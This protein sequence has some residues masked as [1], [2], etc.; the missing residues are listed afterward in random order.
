M[1]RHSSRVHGSRGRNRLYGYVCALSLVVTVSSALGPD[2]TAVKEMIR[3]KF[4]EVS[5]IPTDSL[6]VWQSK[7]RST[8][9]LL[10]DVREDE[11]YVVSHLKAARQSVSEQEALDILKNVPKDTL[12]VLYCSVGY[13]SSKLAKKLKT[14]GFTNVYNLEGSIFEWANRGL[15]VFRGD[16]QVNAVHPF[17]ET[18]GRL[19]DRALWATMPDSA[20]LPEAA[21]SD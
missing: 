17:D 11:E 4:P 9:P 15:P 21:P 3:H 20:S 19:L 5:Q 12:I 16:R 6:L 1:S 18:W 13:R 2:K 7:T 10:L 14:H 8:H